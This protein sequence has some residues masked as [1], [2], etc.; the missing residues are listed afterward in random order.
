LLNSWLEIIIFEVIKW[1]VWIQIRE[2]D[3]LSCIMMMHIKQ[4]K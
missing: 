1:G 4:K 2:G 3:V